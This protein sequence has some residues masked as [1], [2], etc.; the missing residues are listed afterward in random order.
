MERILHLHW[1]QLV[2][3][4][5]TM[6]DP[7]PTHLAS[8]EA[9]KNLLEHLR[10]QEFTNDYL[11]NLSTD[12]FRAAWRLLSDEEEDAATIQTQFQLD[13]DTWSEFLAD[14]SRLPARCDPNI[15]EEFL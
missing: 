10:S 8:L 7:D 9:G 14:V 6:P 15:G 5:L 3:A 11:W 2:L 12:A 13:E 4:L 1:D